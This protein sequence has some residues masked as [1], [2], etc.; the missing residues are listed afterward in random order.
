MKKVMMMAMA[1]AMMSMPVIAH[2]ADM[3]D[4][5]QHKNEMVDMKAKAKFAEMDAN[6]DG[7]ISKSEHDAAGTKMFK[8][9]DGNNDG[10]VSL[11]EMKAEKKKEMDKMDALKPERGNK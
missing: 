9:A 6:K 3:D 11:D 4:S 1:T 7:M 5:A 2:A 8:E 10:M